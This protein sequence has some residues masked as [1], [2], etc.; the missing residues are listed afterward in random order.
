MLVLSS[1]QKKQAEY[2][3]QLLHV[4]ACTYVESCK[5]R[6]VDTLLNKEC[7]IFFKSTFPGGTCRREN[8]PP[9]GKLYLKR[10]HN[11]YA[12]TPVQEGPTSTCTWWRSISFL[13]LVWILQHETKMYTVRYVLNIA[14][15]P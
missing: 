13:T 15:V 5:V 4:Y 1:T 6:L 8:Y 3:L 2:T 14:H 9:P 7:K 12:K 11:M 10:I